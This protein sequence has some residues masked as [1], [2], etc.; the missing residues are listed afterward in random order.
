MEE[1]K[2]VT[3]G[4]LMEVS[5]GRTGADFWKARSQLPAANKNLHAELA[6]GASV[7]CLDQKCRVKDSG[8]WYGKVA[9][10]DRVGG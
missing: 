10:S 5:E 1:R 3:L 7:D 6:A 8:L 4:G 2:R 9:G